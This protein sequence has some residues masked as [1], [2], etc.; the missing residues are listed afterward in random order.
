MLTELAAGRPRPAQ[1]ELDSALQ[2]SPR[3]VKRQAE[4]LR[5]PGPHRGHRRRRA[6][7]DRAQPP[8]RSPAALRR[9]RREPAP[10]PHL[11]EDDPGTAGEMLDM[12]AD[13]VK[14]TIQELRDWL[15]ASYPPLLMDSGLAETPRAGRRTQPP[16]VTFTPGDCRYPTEVEAAVY[17]CCLEALQNAA[18]H[19]PDAHVTLAVG[20]E[21]G[22][23]F[24]R[25][26]DGTGPTWPPWGS[27]TASPTCRTA[28][29]IGGEVAWDSAPA[30]GVTSGWVPAVGPRRHPAGRL[31]PSGRRRQ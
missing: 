31:I 13:N 12:L 24:P 25:R 21:E 16:D 11:L 1:R 8:R 26:D 9:A 2:E 23:C 15:T 18:K 5:L 28:R 3:R 10:R 14:E 29:A 22:G 4:E 27:A 30:S 19:A 7:Q 17:F 20:E 6:A